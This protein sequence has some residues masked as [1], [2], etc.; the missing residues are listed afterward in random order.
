MK[1]NLTGSAVPSGLEYTLQQGFKA[2]TITFTNSTVSLLFCFICRQEK[3]G[4]SA[5]DSE[6]TPLM[7][8]RPL[9][10]F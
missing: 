7:A 5:D 4:W 1:S 3:T 6:A 2:G 9:S 8:G 10:R